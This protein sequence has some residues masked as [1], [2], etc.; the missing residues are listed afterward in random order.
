ML[1]IDGSQGEG[2]GQIL[3][4][5]LSLSVLTKTPFRIEN[6]R[7]GRRRPGLMRQHLTA[8]RAAAE[9]SGAEVDGAAIGSTQLTF[10]PGLVR[11]GDYSFSVGSAGS[12]SLV[13]QTVLPALALADAPST[14]EVRGGTHNPLAPPFDFLVR[15]LFPLLR[16]MGVSVDGTLHRPGYY[17]AGGGHAT[18][19]VQPAKRLEPLELLSR[20]DIRRREITAQVAVLSSD[21]GAREVTAI[22]QALNWDRACGQV[23]RVKNATGP[24]NV[25]MVDVESDEVTEVFSGFG[26]KGVSAEKVGEGVAREVKAYLAADVPVGQHLADQLL[27]WLALA[28]RGCFRTVAP[29]QHTRTHCEVIRTFLNVNAEVAK[30]DGVWMVRVAKQR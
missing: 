1:V 3:R 19:R 12:T 11:A 20:G 13:F 4:S 15:T 14:I 10:T 7:A 23:H 9:I 26:E 28:G 29:T 18:Y 6:I 24:G 5:S 17:P 16:R 27:L 25:V 22:A 8:V 30:D 21:I 2:G